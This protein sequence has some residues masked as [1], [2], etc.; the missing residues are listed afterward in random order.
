MK[1]YLIATTILTI[2]VTLFLVIHRNVIQY[3]S[4]VSIKNTHWKKVHVQVRKGYNPDP[5]HDKLIFDQYISMGQSRTFTVDN[6]D[7]ILYRRDSDPNRPDGIHFTSWTYANCDDTST[8][9]V[10]NP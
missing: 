1:K 9:T 8:C 5:S 6:G 2:M 10:D 4:I 7:D 3:N